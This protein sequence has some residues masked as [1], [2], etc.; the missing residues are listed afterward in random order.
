M[1]VPPLLTYIVLI[2]VF[3]E[4]LEEYWKKVERGIKGLLPLI[5]Q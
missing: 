5:L 1:C 3:L 2:D 4:E